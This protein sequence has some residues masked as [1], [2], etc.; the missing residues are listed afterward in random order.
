MNYKDEVMKYINHYKN[1]IC[2][3]EDCIIECV[4]ILKEVKKY[5]FSPYPFFPYP[6]DVLKLMN[7]ARIFVL[8][9]LIKAIIL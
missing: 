2:C 4:N 3:F 8:T 7:E 9:E 1:G 5:Y 6:K